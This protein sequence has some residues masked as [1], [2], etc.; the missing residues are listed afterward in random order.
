MAVNQLEGLAAS[1]IL[2]LQFFVGA[3]LL[4]EALLLVIRVGEVG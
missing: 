2:T 1:A 3:W 4:V